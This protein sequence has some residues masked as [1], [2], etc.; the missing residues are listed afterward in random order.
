MFEPTY[1]FVP[2]KFKNLIETEPWYA[3]DAK[4]SEKAQGFYVPYI[5]MV[6]IRERWDKA[7][8]KFSELLANFNFIRVAKIMKDMNWTYWGDETSPNEQT[9][10]E[11][12]RGLFDE[13]LVR[14]VK[15]KFGFVESGGF[16]LEYNPSEDQEL[17]LIF[18]AVSESEFL[19]D[20]N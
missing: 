18:Q 8:F 7:W 13:L 19:S 14:I 6:S 3:T 16:R 20:D 11:F 12:V 9:L 4:W 1:S 10:R 5:K 17:K 15:N 2:F